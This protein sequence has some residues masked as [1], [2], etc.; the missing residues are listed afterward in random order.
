MSLYTIPAHREGI[1]DS[2]LEQDWAGFIRH[3]GLRWKREPI[4]IIRDGGGTVVKNIVA[5]PDF[6]LPDVAVPFECKPNV[7]HVAFSQDKWHEEARRLGRPIVVTQS[8]PQPQWISIGRSDVHMPPVL[9]AFD[10]DSPFAHATYFAACPDCDQIGLAAL[11]PDAEEWF[12]GL[13][14]GS[15]V[16]IRFWLSACHHPGRW[17]KTTFW[18]AVYDKRIFPTLRDDP[19]FFRPFLLNRP[20]P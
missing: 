15:T 8:Y 17:N 4:Q 12:Q 9:W 10:E 5:R 6:F 11:S 20:R 7:E 19:A 1:F 14:S 16:P 18:R 2:R 3:C 13:T